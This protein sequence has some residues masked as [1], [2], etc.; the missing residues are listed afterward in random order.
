MAPAA[1]GPHPGLTQLSLCLST[2]LTEHDVSLNTQSLLGDTGYVSVSLFA[3]LGHDHPAFMDS[4]KDFGI[5]PALGADGPARAKLRLERTR[6]IAAFDVAKVRNNI[7]TG[8]NAQRSATFKVTKLS[9]QDLISACRAFERGQH[10]LEEA[11][12]RAAHCADVDL[13]RI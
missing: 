4:L 10:S 7:E 8:E 11:V 5:D 13:L 2:V 6:L 9:I 1:V 12:L 3:A